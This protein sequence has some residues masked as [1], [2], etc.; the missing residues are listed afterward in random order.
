MR[1][2]VGGRGCGKIPS[3]F[4][5]SI[6]SAWTQFG[7]VAFKQFKN[8]SRKIKKLFID[9]YETLFGDLDCKY[10]EDDRCYLN[11]NKSRNNKYK[12]FGKK[13]I[14]KNKEYFKNKDKINK[15]VHQLF[16][17]SKQLRHFVLSRENIIMK[18]IVSHIVDSVELSGFGTKSF[19]TYLITSLLDGL[20]KD[21]SFRSLNE[22][23][24]MSV[25]K[26]GAKV[27]L[28]HYFSKV[29][30][31]L[32]CSKD[33]LIMSVVCSSL[34]YKD[35]TE[36]SFVGYFYHAPN[37][38]TP[39]RSYGLLNYCELNLARQNIDADILCDC[40]EDVDDFSIEKLRASLMPLVSAL[41]EECEADINSPIPSI[42]DIQHDDIFSDKSIQ[43]RAEEILTNI[44]YCPI[45]M[46]DTDG[47]DVDEVKE[48]LKNKNAVNLAEHFDDQQLALVKWGNFLSDNILTSYID[49]YATQSL[50]KP[51]YRVEAINYGKYEA[52]DL[53]KEKLLSNLNTGFEFGSW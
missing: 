32:P 11:N 43:Q 30:E 37:C 7:K 10:Y 25:L 18:D 17:N 20:N 46:V 21:E 2:V 3:T 29:K 42:D 8:E 35:D 36:V 49:E 13:T 51:S 38:H 1:M 31:G 40:N 12:S 24:Q 45:R 16:A 9:E 34:N 27:S 4:F 50:L 48:L 44:V 6:N 22:E 14:Y 28:E 15:T 47:E 53:T 52:M 19:R 41:L 39:V 26:H 5:D 23:D 33:S